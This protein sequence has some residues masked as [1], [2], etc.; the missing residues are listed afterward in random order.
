MKVCMEGVEIEEQNN[1][2][3]ELGCNIIQGFYYYLSM[4]LSSCYRL[5]SE[6]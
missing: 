1:V 3:Q 4:E 5:L 6:M 2:I